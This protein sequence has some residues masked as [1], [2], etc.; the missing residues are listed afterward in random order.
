MRPGTKAE[1]RSNEGLVSAFT[2]LPPAL[3][4]QRTRGSL[5]L[6]FSFYSFSA[7][8]LALLRSPW[9]RIGGT[10]VRERHRP[11]FSR[12]HRW[13]FV[14]TGPAIGSPD[15]WCDAGGDGDRAGPTY[16]FF[17]RGTRIPGFRKTVFHPFFPLPLRNAALRAI[18]SSLPEIARC[19]STWNGFSWNWTDQFQQY[20]SFCFL[21]S[22]ITAVASRY[23]YKIRLVAKVITLIL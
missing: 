7:F 18:Q 2:L 12:Q 13:L 20:R 15:T 4:Y 22:G 5:S 23:A 17:Q 19:L 21:F 1:S 11:T 16:H 9:A 14:Y 6:L 10:M 8:L 3:T